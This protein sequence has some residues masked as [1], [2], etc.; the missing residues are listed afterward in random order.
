MNPNGRNPRKVS[1]KPT[2]SC[3]ACIELYAEESS[4]PKAS[5]KEFCPLCGLPHFRQGRTC[6]NIKS[7]TQVNAMMNALKQSVEPKQLVDAATKYLQ[8]VKDKLV[9]QRKQKE[10][11]LLANANT[12]GVGDVE[13]PDLQAMA[14]SKNKRAE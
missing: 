11:D 9:Q 14:A 6:P 2:C 5:G 3:P 10:A 8:S 4:S 1:G 13:R 7:E 12:N